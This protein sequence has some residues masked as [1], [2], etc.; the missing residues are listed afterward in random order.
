[1]NILSSPKMKRYSGK[2]TE[3]L[4][5]SKSINFSFPSKKLTKYSRDCREKLGNSLVLPWQE[6]PKKRNAFTRTWCSW[7][8]SESYLVNK[9]PE[10][11]GSI[12]S[13]PTRPTLQNPKWLNFGITTDGVYENLLTVIDVFSRHL[14]AYHRSKQDAKTIAKIIKKHNDQARPITKDKHFG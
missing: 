12:A 2:T 13:S 14:F 1:M 4:I 5:A 6:M 9:E 7:S 11:D 3:K 10:N 8:R